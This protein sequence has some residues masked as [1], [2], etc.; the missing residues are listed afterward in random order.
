VKPGSTQQKNPHSL[1]FIHLLMLIAATLV[2]TSF[3]VGA[4]ITAELD[5]AVLTLVRF[6]LAACIFGPWVHFKYGLGFSLSL[7]LRC[8]LISGCLVIFFCSMFLALR[9]TSALNISVI[10]ALVP[11]ISGIYALII[12]GERLHKGQLLAL[13]CGMIG[14]V[15]VV[16]QGDISQ[17]LALDWNRGD[18]IFFGGCVAM[19]LYTP[20]VKLLHRGESMAIMTFWV[21]V[22]GSLWLLLITGSKL[23]TVAWDLV[24]TF[25]WLGIAYLVVFTTIVT[26]FLTQY[27]VSYLGPTRVAAYSYL[28]P[29]L[30][31]VI[32]LVLGHGLPPLQVIPGIFVVLMAMFVIQ[33]TKNV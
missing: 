25:A 24:P 29:G 10:F 22:S 14:V 1:P 21:L 8:A 19:G 2:S 27:S 26:F 30:V 28:Y 11:S 6:T 12:L 32:D 31:L 15:W 33:N 18:L 4:A 9:Y 13:A 23:T 7:F 5:P 16:F 20:L 3:T 17:F